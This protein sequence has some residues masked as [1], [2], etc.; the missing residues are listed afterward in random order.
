MAIQDFQKVDFLWKKLLFGVSNTTTAGK[1]GYN[2]IYS[3][4]VPTYADNIWTQSGMIQSPAPEQTIGVHQYYGISTAVEC[5]TDPTV[6]GNRTWISVSDHGDL[7]TRLR[8]WISP[9]FDPTYLITVYKGD[10][11]KGGEPLNQ[12]TTNEE[13][14]FDYITGVLTFPNNVPSGVNNSNSDN[15]IFIVGHRYTGSKGITGSGG[16]SASYVVADIPERDA[17]SPNDGDTVHVKNAFGDVSNRAHIGE[18]EFA[19]YIYID[20][21]WVLTSTQDSSEADKGSSSYTIDFDSESGNFIN[22]RKGTRITSVVV[23]VTEVFDG[24]NASLDIGDSE[25]GNSIVSDDL[26]DLTEIGTYTIDSTK[27]FQEPNS[28]TYLLDAD[29]SQQ[30]SATII[31]KWAS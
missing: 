10:P 22:V 6:A 20:G 21:A 12:G 15:R 5:M 9:T 24:Q 3:S 11:A 2:E 30:G 25:V 8:N 14:V 31:I 18:G 7:S 26:V 13:W 17:L 19:N 4:P 1:E 16:A 28:V 29:G 23:D 27:L